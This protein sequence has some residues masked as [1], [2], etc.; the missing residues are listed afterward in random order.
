VI[1]HAITHFC[2]FSLLCERM[3]IHMR[4]LLGASAF[5]HLASD[6]CS[7]ILCPLAY[8]LHAHLRIAGVS[9]T[10]N[11]LAYN[12]VIRL[13]CELGEIDEAYNI[14]NEMASHGEKP[15]VWSYTTV[16]NTHCLLKEVNKALWII[17][18]MDDGSC[19]PNLVTLIT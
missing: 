15:D 9:L 14:L 5:F 19:F 8:P 11:I 2:A 17:S 1:G 6:V 10:P 18:R 4:M 16:L 7:R 3:R 13:L 12:V